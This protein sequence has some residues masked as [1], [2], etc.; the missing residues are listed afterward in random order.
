MKKIVL[1]LALSLVSFAPGCFKASAPIPGSANA[2]DSNTYLSLVTAKG[3]IDQAKADLAASAFPPAIAAKV[4][5]A[6]NDAVNAYNIADLTYQQYHTAAIAN[7]ATVAQQ[8]ATTSAV[9]NLQT[10]VANVTAAKAGN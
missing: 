3:V 10:E 7:A 8:V 4:K 5:T 1:F 2:F 6:V 9:N